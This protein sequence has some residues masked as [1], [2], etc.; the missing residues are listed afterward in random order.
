MATSNQITLQALLL[1]IQLTLSA[2]RIDN[3]HSPAVGFS[4]ARST[5]L[6]ESGLVTFDIVLID[7]HNLWKS[8]RN[9]FIASQ[10]GVYFFH[11]SVGTVESSFRYFGLYANKECIV[12]LVDGLSTLF[13]DTGV[14]LLNA[15]A[16]TS[17]KVG[18]NVTMTTGAGKLWST[19]TTCKCH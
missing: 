15:C 14:D 2:F 1:C 4:V 16:M 19:K 3:Y 11:F 6:K 12:Q 8:D 9:C 18:D 7:T 10:N 5:P 17:L 13:T